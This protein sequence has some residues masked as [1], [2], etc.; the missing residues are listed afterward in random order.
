MRAVEGVQENQG[1]KPKAKIEGKNRSQNMKPKH[2]AK[3]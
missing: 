3:T 1:A 2:E